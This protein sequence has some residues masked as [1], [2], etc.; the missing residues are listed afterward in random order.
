MLNKKNKIYYPY[1][2]GIYL[3]VNAIKN[4]FILVDSPF[5]SYDSADNLKK[6][7]MFS[8]IIESRSSHRFR[9]SGLDPKAIAMEP[10]AQIENL[11]MEISKAKECQ[12]IFF[13]SM[14]L[15]VVSGTQ[16]DLIAKRVSKKIKKSLIYI[17]PKSFNSDYLKGFE[18]TLEAVTDNLNLKRG[19]NKKGKVAIVG[20][21]YDRNEGDHSGN[22]RELNVILKKLSLE[23]VSCW[24]SGST[25]DELKKIEE[26]GVI[27]SLPYARRAAKKI[28]GLTGAKLLE[29]DIPFGLEGTRK[30]I[31][32]IA[33]HYKMKNAAKKIIEEE[34]SSIIPVL[35]RVVQNYFQGKKISI[36]ADPY[37]CKAISTSLIELGAIIGHNIIFSG[38]KIKPPYPTKVVVGPTYDKIRNINFSDVDMIIGNSYM[39]YFAYK[40]KNYNNFIEFGYPSENYHCLTEEPYLLYKGFLKFINRIVNNVLKL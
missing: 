11:I 21:F 3:S 8:D 37:M 5:C 36:G 27:I 28:A 40:S 7:D 25:F 13:T 39:R 4:S 38:K 23:L 32:K 31:I 14:P 10:E 19:K 16:H 24:L 22:M 34:L 35:N 33:E 1:L 15:S 30:F 18:D 12:A 2:Y 29:L 20:Y 6:H 9:C 26:A 17:P